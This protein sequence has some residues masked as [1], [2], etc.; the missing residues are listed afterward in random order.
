MRLKSLH[1]QSSQPEQQVRNRYTLVRGIDDQHDDMLLPV[2]ALLKRLGE[3]A[4]REAR[5]ERRS[6]LPNQA[7]MVS[8]A[9]PVDHGQHLGCLVLPE[10]RRHTVTD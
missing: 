3:S 6:P 7:G 10:Y 8:M 2:R 4:A 9:L 1:H 5:P